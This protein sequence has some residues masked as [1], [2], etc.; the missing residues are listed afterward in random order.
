VLRTIHIVDDDPSFRTSTGRLL[1]LSGYEVVLYDRAEALLQ[2][3]PNELSPGCVLLD[4]RI[5]GMSGPEL[6]TRLTQLGSLLP[7]V[8]LTGHPDIQ[9]TVRAVK[10]GAEDVLVKPVR[11][12]NLIEALERAFHRFTVNLSERSRLDALR[13]SL[14]ALTPRERQVFEG[15]VRGKMNKQI[16]HELDISERTVKAH[17]SKVMEK[18]DAN[19]LAELVVIGERLGLS[20]P[21]QNR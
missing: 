14:A 19:S 17:R 3:L 9:T 15:V 8:F 18:M 1:Q 4:V 20:R 5:P 2:Q 13:S 7:I 10:A 21:E 6:Q 11:K 12:E 16:A